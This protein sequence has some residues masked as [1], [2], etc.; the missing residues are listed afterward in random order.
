MLKQE[1]ATKQIRV[2]PSS[3]G[4]LIRLLKARKKQYPRS[5][6]AD[7][8]RDLLNNAEAEK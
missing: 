1:T 6:I 2:Y 7:V 5:V 4:G 8:I 3:E